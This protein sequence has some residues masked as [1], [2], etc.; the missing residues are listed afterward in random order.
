MT[1]EYLLMSLFWNERRGSTYMTRM[2]RKP[3]T[4]RVYTVKTMKWHD[5][6][7]RSFD[8]RWGF[9]SCFLFAPWK[10]SIFQSVVWQ[11]VSSCLTCYCPHHVV[12]YWETSDTREERGKPRVRHETWEQRTSLL[13]QKERRGWRPLKGKSCSSLNKE[14]LNSEQELLLKLY[15]P[16]NNFKGFE[17]KQEENSLVWQLSLMHEIFKAVYTKFSSPFLHP[18][19][20][21][22]DLSLIL[23]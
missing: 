10:W 18:L 1:H 9:S 19:H 12:W 20:P 21:T 7:W 17:V 16:S 3:T 22:R 4:R 13:H 14:G 23:S 11:S 15:F 2:T 5:T 6:A 8:Q